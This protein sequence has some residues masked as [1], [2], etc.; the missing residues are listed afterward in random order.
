LQQHPQ[1]PAPVV[2]L[3]SSMS[4][5][6]MKAELAEAPLTASLGRSVVSYNLATNGGGPITHLVY[7]Q[8]LLRRGV[9]PELVVLEVSPLLFCPGQ[10][11]LDIRRFPAEVLEHQDLDII[12][13][14]G[15][16]PDLRDEWW[17]SQL[18]PA[19]GH[20]LMILN[21][22]ARVL[23]PFNDQIDLWADVDEHGW[24]GR[25]AL[26]PEMHG[27]ALTQI[28]FQLKDKLAKFT[29]DE[30]PLKGLRELTDLL[31]K[32]RIKAVLVVMPAGPFLRSLYAPGS[33]APVM[34]EFAAVSRQHGF[35]LI[36]AQEWYDESSFVDSYH[37]HDE[38]ADGFTQ[39]LVREVLAPAVGSHGGVAS[40]G[41]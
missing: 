41:R 20:R 31:A 26:A 7:V 14:H 16:Q 11:S 13:R 40:R 36:D 35:T 39:R 17:K 28:E 15:N 32:E 6:G 37:L 9:R 30:A 23:V 3:G 2:F 1:P 22:S 27:V 33:T 10:A 8:R 19:Y 21:Q 12:E 4:A 24:R 18:V 5:N 25:K 38:A 29:I 34:A